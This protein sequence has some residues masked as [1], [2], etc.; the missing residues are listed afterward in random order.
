MTV[1]VLTVVET[2]DVTVV[3]RNRKIGERLSSLRSFF[4][5]FEVYLEASISFDGCNLGR[6]DAGI[7]SITPS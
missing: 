2:V 3:I 7:A 1:A 4:S 6:S 5:P